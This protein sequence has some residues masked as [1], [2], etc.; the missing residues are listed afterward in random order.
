MLSAID[1]TTAAL[2]PPFDLR[3]YRAYNPGLPPMS[4]AELLYHYEAHGRAEGRVCSEV[5]N[6]ASFL[7]LVPP[8]A[9][10]LEIG[11]SYTPAFRRPA[12]HVVYIDVHDTEELRRRADADPAAGSAPE[13]DGPVVPEIDH[14]WRGERYR[15]LIREDFDV[16]L[17]AG[18]NTHQPNLVMHHRR[19]GRP[20]PGPH[21]PRHGPRAGRPD[22][23]HA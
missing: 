6:R 2:P 15:E 8:S 3:A 13:D 10:I 22:D 16:V 1:Q 18:T 7:K 5:Y 20:C 9:K 12:H 19:A 4:D 11:P 17:A 21:P 14:V 23:A